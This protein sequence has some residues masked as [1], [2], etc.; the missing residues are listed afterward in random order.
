L[1]FIISVN[2]IILVTLKEKKHHQ[3]PYI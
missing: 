3:H 1:N 2:F